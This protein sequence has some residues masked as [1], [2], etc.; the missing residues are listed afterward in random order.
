MPNYFIILLSVDLSKKRI[1]GHLTVKVRCI[2][3]PG[4]EV[5]LKWRKWPA[6]RLSQEDK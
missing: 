1:H 6:Y 2:S 3:V 5:R 4:A